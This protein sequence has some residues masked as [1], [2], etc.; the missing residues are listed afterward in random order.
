MKSCF[1]INYWADTDEKIQMVIEG[2]KQL[3][4]T[5]RDIVYTSLYPIDKKISEL[6]TYSIFHNKNDLITLFNLLD[7]DD[8]VMHHNVSFDTDNFRFFSTPLKWNDVGYS[9]STQLVN[10]LKTLKSLG[11][12]YFHFFVGDCSISDEELKTFDHIEESCKLY[13][14]KAYFDD[15]THR[16]DGFGSIYFSSDIQFFLDHF[17]KISSKNEFI[18]TNRGGSGIFCFEKILK[19]C[20]ES[21]SKDLLLGKNDQDSFGHSVLFKT[22][23]L[24]IVSTY[25]SGTQYHIIPNIDHSLAYLFVTSKEEANY[26]IRIDDENYE[27][28]LP[29]NGWWYKITDKKQFDLKILK[30]NRIDFDETITEARL[31]RIYSYSFFD[32]NKRNI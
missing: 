19:N 6:T 3:K 32:S 30:N 27:C 5:S 20:F 26:T 1:L 2:I 29:K 21:K 31:N 25:N 24:D 8:V 22:S 13:N 11:Y 15:L 14:K 10:N 12:D 18:K 28:F 7:T 4:K 16:F 17:L 23:K 9:V